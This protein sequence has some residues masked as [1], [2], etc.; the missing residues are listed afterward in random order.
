MFVLDLT[1]FVVC[2]SVFNLV[3]SKQ[4]ISDVYLNKRIFASSKS[5]CLF[6]KHGIEL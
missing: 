6:P 2:L 5:W 1:H 4:Q 3:G